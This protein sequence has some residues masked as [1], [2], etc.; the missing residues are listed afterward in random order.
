MTRFKPDILISETLLTFV[1][2]FF[3]STASLG[4]FFF[5]NTSVYHLWCE[6]KGAKKVLKFSH[7]FHTF[8]GTKL[9][10]V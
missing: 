10:K 8:L 4:I 5:T 3:K 6:K 9:K 1:E 7:N 2:L